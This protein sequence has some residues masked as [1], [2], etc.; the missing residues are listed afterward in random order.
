MA[1]LLP[2]LETLIPLV[3]VSAGMLLALIVPAILD[4]NTFLPPLLEEKKYFRV[5]LLVFENGFYAFVGIFFLIAGVK[6]NIQH[7]M[8]K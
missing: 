8:N 4:T 6:T 1:S 3:G 5:W 7:L 2:S